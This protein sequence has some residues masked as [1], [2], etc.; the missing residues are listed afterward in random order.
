MTIKY[1]EISIIRYYNSFVNGLMKP[2]KNIHR[3]DVYGK[4][5]N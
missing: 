5:N 2:Q 3:T 4:Y 1:R